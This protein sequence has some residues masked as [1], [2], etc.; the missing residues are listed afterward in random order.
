[1][2]GES[3][4]VRA[5]KRTGLC[6]VSHGGSDRDELEVLPLADVTPIEP[7][8]DDSVSAERIGFSLHAIHRV[9]PRSVR[10]LCE[11]RQFRLLPEAGELGPDVIH[12]GAHDQLDRF[13]AGTVQKRELVDRQIGSEYLP[14]VR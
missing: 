8:T 5:P 4:S 3:L 10:R 2:T 7:D 6:G 11:H 9:P 12:R 13:E 14:S 1:M